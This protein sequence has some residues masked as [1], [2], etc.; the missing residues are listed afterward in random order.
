MMFS[1]ELLKRPKPFEEGNLT[2]WS[3]D[4]IADNVLRRHL[5]GNVDSGSRKRNT[6]IEAAKW[7]TSKCIEKSLIS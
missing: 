4:Y 7:I 6:I 5:D 1:L 2:L 3:D